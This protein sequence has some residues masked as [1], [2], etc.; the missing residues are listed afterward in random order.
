MAFFLFGFALGSVATV[1]TLKGLCE[2]RLPTLN[3]VLMALLSGKE[4]D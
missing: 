2:G 3:K 1:A 4:S